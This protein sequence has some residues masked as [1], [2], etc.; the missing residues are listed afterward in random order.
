MAEYFP[1]ED[2][3]FEAD[4]QR[5]ATT[6]AD[7]PSHR[8]LTATVVAAGVLLTLLCVVFLFMYDTADSDRSVQRTE[9]SSA[10]AESDAPNTPENQVARNDRSTELRLIEEQ[11]IRDSKLQKF[12]VRRQDLSESFDELAAEMRS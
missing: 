7:D 10:P 5:P 9:D 4:D 12:K 6:E 3:D 1:P 2:D 11:A 8:R